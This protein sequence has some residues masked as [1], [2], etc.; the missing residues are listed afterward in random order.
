MRF[1]PE[2]KML[3]LFLFR[4]F[5]HH[6]CL[7]SF[8]LFVHSFSPE[9]ICVYYF[10]LLYINSIKDVQRCLYENISH[11]ENFMH[12]FTE[13][14]FMQTCYME[15]ILSLSSSLILWEEKSKARSS[16]TRSCF[17]AHFYIAKIFHLQSYRGK[18]CYTHSL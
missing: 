5:H 17:Y 2:Q 4:T 12:I 11:S 1:K 8:K 16:G 13:N 10:G 7:C 3:F 9:M 14:S 18:P 6:I 15:Q